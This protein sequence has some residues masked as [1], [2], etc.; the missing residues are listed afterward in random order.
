MS[1]RRSTWPNLPAVAVALLIAGCSTVT[2]FAP[3]PSGPCL[4]DLPEISNW[5]LDHLAVV[6]LDTDGRTDVVRFTFD[7]TDPG[8]ASV[9]AEPATGRWVEVNTA[10]PVEPI[11]DR[12]TSVKFEGLLTVD[13][14]ER[15]GAD[16]VDP[17]A[18]V[19]DVVWVDHPNVTRFII[20]T[21]AGA[22]LRMR[23]D[24]AAGTVTVLVTRP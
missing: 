24:A 1:T 22:C 23:Q 2:P 7:P 10:Q 11:G 21:V 13:G 3:E 17:I 14:A 15:L 20:G 4:G 5:G 9:T 6:D 8:V 12:L 16:P 19:R 18:A